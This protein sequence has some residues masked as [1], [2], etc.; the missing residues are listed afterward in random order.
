MAVSIDDFYL[1]RADQEKIALLHSDNALLQVRGTFGTHDTDLA[2]STL[3]DLRQVGRGKQAVAVPVYDK[4]A[5]QG[6]GDRA[7]RDRWT[8]V[9]GPVDVVLFEGWNLVRGHGT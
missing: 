5:F 1:T 8:V 6:K 9:D 3:K 4:S 2:L 7:P